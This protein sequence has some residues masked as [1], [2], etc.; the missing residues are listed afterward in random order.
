MRQL[1]DKSGIGH[2]VVGEA[3]RMKHVMDMVDCEDAHGNTPLSEA[4]S[5]S[6]MSSA[7]HNAHSL[8]VSYITESSVTYK[9]LRHI[10]TLSFCESN[11]G[12]KGHIN[13]SP[14]GLYHVTFLQPYL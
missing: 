9:W 13:Y 1:D 10:S 4:S 5:E 14:V 7:P 6:C 11:S 12:L 2:D 8:S 3:V